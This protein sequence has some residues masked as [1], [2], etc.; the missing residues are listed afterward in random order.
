MKLWKMGQTIGAMLLFSACNSLES[1]PTEPPLID[2][3][4][5]API[6][7]PVAQPQP[8]SASG[9]SLDM[10]KTGYAGCYD[11]EALGSTFVVDAHN[12]FRPFGGAAISMPEINQYLLDTGV[13][14]VNVFGIGQSLPIDS[15]C[16]YYLDCIGTPA[17]PSM[18]NDFINAGNYLDTDPAG[19]VMTFSMTFPD[20]AKPETILPNMAVI[21]SE[22]PGMFTWMGEVNLVKQALFGNSHFATPA[23][24]IEGWSGF[25]AEL[26]KRNMPISIHADL[27]NN[28]EETKFGPLMGRVLAL[29]PDNKIVWVHMGLSKELTTI[30]AEKH[31]AIMQGYLDAYPNLML[32]IS[33]RVISDNYFNDPS[34]RAKYIDF[35]ETNPDRILTGTD[36]VASHK[37]SFEI[38]KEEVE[39]NS[40]ILKDLS[41]DAFRKIGLGQ[42]YFEL[43]GLD[44]VAP[45]VCK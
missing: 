1:S 22:Y 24:A 44:Y 5:P 32:D 35:F 17:L 45:E 37:K 23:S 21:D 10:F 6:L 20:L 2:A 34:Q 41:D 27:G 30:S 39:V 29:Y 12:H 26:R 28:E 4:P 16:E 40:D 7:E 33:W 18:K 19:T 8:L 3:N 42:N 15:P 38:Y 36:F 31:I 14:F 9:R 11:R 25:M 43:T 13:L